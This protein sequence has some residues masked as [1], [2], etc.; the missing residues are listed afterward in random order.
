MNGA[1][2]FL[3]VV[4]SR[5]TSA[6]SS[7]PSPIIGALGSRGPPAE[8][9]RPPLSQRFSPGISSTLVRLL[10]VKVGQDDKPISIASVCPEGRKVGLR[11][12]GVHT[13]PGRVKVCKDVG[14][15]ARY[16]GFS[17]SFRS[18]V[19]PG[20]PLPLWMADIPRGRNQQATERV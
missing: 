8:T 9:C 13:V 12:A 15:G 11:S 14:G 6:G 3:I 4:V 18:R 2:C 17:W 5:L 19:L 10:G 1:P 16:R 7:Y 20:R